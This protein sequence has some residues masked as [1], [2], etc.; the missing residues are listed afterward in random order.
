MLYTIYK[1]SNDQGLVY[2]GSTRDTLNSRL[3]KHKHDLLRYNNGRY[4]YVTSFSVLQGTD[5]KIEKIDAIDTED[6][7]DVLELEGYYI[8][9]NVC[10]N[11][12]QAGRTRKQYYQD[13]KEAILQKQKIY[14]ANKKM[15]GI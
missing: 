8:A 9:N 10:V 12:H 15:K 14:N 3:S 11:G 5:P 1:I 6:I 2:Y 13:N 7:K 4:H